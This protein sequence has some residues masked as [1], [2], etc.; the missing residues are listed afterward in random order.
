VRI[1]LPHLMR[2]T[3]KRFAMLIA[4]GESLPRKSTPSR[5][6]AFIEPMECL[7]VPRV[8]GSRRD[9][10]EEGQTARFLVHMSLQGKRSVPSPGSHY[11]I[12]ADIVLN[13]VNVPRFLV[14]NCQLT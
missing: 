11:R 9:R 4:E 2:P 12:V 5:T 6:A 7:P 8:P 13:V 14:R 10:L 1:L 3:G